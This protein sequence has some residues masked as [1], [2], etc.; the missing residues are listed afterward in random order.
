M[1]KKGQNRQTV[2]LTPLPLAPPLPA[3]TPGAKKPARKPLSWDLQSLSKAYEQGYLAG[4]MGMVRDSCPY[5]GA[6]VAAAWE[7]GWED[8]LIE[9]SRGAVVHGSVV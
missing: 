1:A 3:R 6:V 8:G 9:R 5:L 4:T 2:T 7:G